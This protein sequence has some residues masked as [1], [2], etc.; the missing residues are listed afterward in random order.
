MPRFLAPNKEETAGQQKQTT[1]QKNYYH[2]RKQN[3]GGRTTF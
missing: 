3:C 2:A 1:L